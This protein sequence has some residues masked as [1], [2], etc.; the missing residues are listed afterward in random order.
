[1]VFLFFKKH[2]QL[3]IKLLYSFQITIKKLQLLYYILIFTFRCGNFLKI[4]LIK[5][6]K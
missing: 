4:I 5:I 6:I 1:M 2:I 3:Y